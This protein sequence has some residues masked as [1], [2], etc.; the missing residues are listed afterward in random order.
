MSSAQLLLAA[1]Y[2]LTALAILAAGYIEKEL[3]NKK[4]KA[5][6]SKQS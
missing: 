5:E 2:G 1:L 4:H 3:R 6:D